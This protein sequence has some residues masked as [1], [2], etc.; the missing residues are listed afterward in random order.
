MKVFSLSLILLAILEIST[1][2][3]TS[4]ELIAV[5]Q[6][7]VVDYVDTEVERKLSSKKSSKKSEKK[8]KKKNKIE[9]CGIMKKKPTNDIPE[10]LI[11]L[12]FTTLV[13]ALIAA[14]FVAIFAYPNG[15][16]TVFAPTELAFAALPDG[17]LSCLLLPES[18]GALTS[19]ILYHV[20]QGTAYSCD[21]SD[22]QKVMTMN[23]EEVVVDK[24][25]EVMIN[26]STVI[27]ANLLAKNG[28]VHAI[29]AVLVPPTFD[30]AAFLAA[31]P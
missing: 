4:R 24:K 23:G 13:A 9:V 19:I 22:G 31:C 16:Y 1:T 11:A 27:D 18:L 15:P 29:D 30:V 21:V 28:V 17:L 25:S 6:D 5:D 2:L 10:K 20:V 7:Y 26:L 3:V 12:D 14:N 8:K